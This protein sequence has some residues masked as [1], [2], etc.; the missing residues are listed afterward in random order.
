MKLLKKDTT[1]QHMIDK[2]NDSIKERIRKPITLKLKD[3][4]RKKKELVEKEMFD[5][6]AKKNKKNKKRNLNK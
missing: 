5:L 4:K 6:S 1:F 3:I 2:Y